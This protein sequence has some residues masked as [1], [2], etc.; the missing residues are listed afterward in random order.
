MEQAA[1]AVISDAVRSYARKRARPTSSLARRRSIWKRGLT[2]KLP[3]L[4]KF[5]RFVSTG[6]SGSYINVGTDAT[7]QICF[8]S[9]TVSGQQLQMDFTLDAFRIYIDGTQV[10][11]IVPPGYGELGALFDKYRI[12]AVEIFYAY[13][14][15]GNSDQTVGGSTKMPSVVFTVDTDDS[16]ATT[17]QDLQ[18][19]TTAKYLQL[20]GVQGPAKRLVKFKPLPSLNLFTTPTTG[21]GIGDLNT[22][23]LWL[24]C[25]TPTIRH[26]GVKMAIDNLTLS[27]TV[28]STYGN[29]QF[30]CRYHLSFKGVR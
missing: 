6:Q 29:L 13:S 1:A 26:Y 27:S 30:Q 2:S 12:D 22:K 25:G 7:G 18:Q 28:N 24:D 17:P 3:S 16:G 14:A 21:G 23:N 5:T 11:A 20:A 15:D 19:Y 4:Y 9:P 8:K 10:M